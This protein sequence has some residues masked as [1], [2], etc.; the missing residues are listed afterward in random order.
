MTRPRRRLI[1]RS[2]TKVTNSSEQ[3][4]DGDHQRPGVADD[5]PEVPGGDGLLKDRRRLVCRGTEV[6]AVSAATGATAAADCRAAIDQPSPPT[7]AAR[8]IA[9]AHGK[10]LTP[11]M[12]RHPVR[13]AVAS[14]KHA[15]RRV[16]MPKHNLP[17][18]PRYPKVL[19]II[20]FVFG[21]AWR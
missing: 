4:E 16:I 15:V 6:L 9:A 20:I 7:A 13:D 3:A 5:P 1:A 8:Q 2:R 17:A 12:I 18:T 19:P 10:C 14:R 21:R 11:I